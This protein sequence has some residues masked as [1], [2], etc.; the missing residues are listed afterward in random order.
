MLTQENIRSEYKIDDDKNWNTLLISNP[1]LTIEKPSFGSHKVSIRTRSSFNN[2]W[3][4]AYFDFNVDYPWFLHPWMYLAYILGMF[5][6]VL[7]YIRFKTLIYQRRQRILESE[8]AVKT[9]SLNDLNEY[10]QKRNQAKDHVIAIMNHDILTPLKYLHITAKTTAE[11]IEEADL[12]NS[13]HQIAKTSKELEYLTANMLNW[14][15]FENFNSL[16]NQQNIDLYQF[17]QSLIEFVAP[18]K[19]NDTIKIQNQIPKDTI[20][21]NWPDALRVVLYNIIVN[22]I[23]STNQGE[24]NVLFKQSSLDYEIIIQ[25]T[26]EGM[27]ASMVNFLITGKSRD[28]VESLPK[29]KKGNG[30]GYQIIRHLVKIMNAELTITSKEYQGTKV[31]LKFKNTN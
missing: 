13:I 26:G 18:F 21:A 7:L 8:V 23:K 14:V 10:L 16:P 3:E 4:Y 27:S 11:Q 2:K 24:M 22:A 9:A 12:K 17:I 1:Y 29:Y 5:G 20:I 15:K 6:L 28:E 19:L 25:D 30:I 31:S